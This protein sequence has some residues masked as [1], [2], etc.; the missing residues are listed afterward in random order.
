MDI[1]SS[2]VEFITELFVS[3]DSLLLEV[4]I[5]LVLAAVLGFIFQL[6]KQ[7]LI[8]AYLITGIIIGALG[9]F[10]L[11]ER[12]ALEF[13]SHLGVMF[14]LFLVGLEMD[15][16]S[17]K[18]VGKTSLA[19]GLGQVVFTA[20]GGFLLTHF[21]FG[22]STVH[23]AYV[24][25]AL[26]F[27]STVIIVKLLSDKGNLTSLHGRAAVGLLLVQDMVVILI[28]ISLNAFDAG[29]Q[30]G[31]GLIS[32]IVL[33]GATLFGLMMVLGRTVFPYIFRK[34]AGSQE[35]LF[36][37]SLAW[38]LFFSVVVGLAGF[39]IEIAGFLG[40]VAL[41]NS[42]QKYHIASKIQPLRDFFILI[43]F[44]VLGSL[45]AVSD[46]SG[47][48]VPIIVLSLFV[49]IGNPVIVMLIMK[50]LG[51]RKRTNFLTG[52]TVA[53]ISEFSLI[54]ATLGLSMGHISDRVFALIAAVGVVTITTSTYLILYAE[55]IFP[56]IS[57]FLS[58]FEKKS[59]DKEKVEEVNLSKEVVLIGAQR[60]GRG[61]MNYIDS[62]KLMVIDFDPVIIDKLKERGI[63]YLFS[64]ITD[65]HVFNNINLSETKLIISTSPHLKDNLN[66]I[67]RVRE[68]REDIKIVVRAE[69]KSDA[70]RLY[71]E[72]ADYVLFPHFI[73]GQYLG[74]LINQDE[75]LNQLEKLKDKDFKF[76]VD[77]E[78]G[79]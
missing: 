54:F 59:I 77:E 60:T 33:G 65:P 1:L 22:M 52:V 70:L 12:E 3:F 51:Y 14:L 35:L 63:K 19:I 24:A 6:L 13:F 34:V 74:N 44:T 38:L 50:Y 28:L 45:M 26:T 72:G 23:A 49:L 31:I 41:A 18:K 66:L 47:L 7:P 76:L 10:D 9:F 43:F 58:L 39:S 75:E 27:S 36:L 73:S 29:G 32:L 15:Y 11:G 46:F 69:L 5:I 67:S 40:G 25:I 2:G 71:K 20:T 55:E 56:Y 8:L 42:S 78:Y 62:K 4:A 61:I 30:V 21:I 16:E 53:Q 79:I 17:I 48:A 64:D 57:K 37:F 68:K